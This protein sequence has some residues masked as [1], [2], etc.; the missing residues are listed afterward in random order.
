MVRAIRAP[1]AGSQPR[2][3][4]D[5]AQQLGPKRGQAGPRLHHAGERGRE[6]P[7]RQFVAD[8][9]LAKLKTLT[10]AQDGDSVFFVADQADTAWKFAGQARTKIGQELGVIAEDEFALC[11]VVDLP[12]FEYYRQAEEDRLQ[13]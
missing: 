12:M 4:F 1:K 13:P 7:D 6:G 3:F 2:S 11:W 10:G 5:K 8:E 9:R